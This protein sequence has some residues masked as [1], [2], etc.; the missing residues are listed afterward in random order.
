MWRIKP[1]NPTNMLGTD[2][3]NKGRQWA[4]LVALALTPHLL[5][6]QA[7]IALT[8]VGTY[9]TGSFNA[10]AAEI[11]DFDPIDQRIYFTNAQANTVIALD[12]TDPAALQL[13]FSIDLSPYGAG[14]NSVVVLAGGIAVAVE[15]DPKTDPGSVVF[16]DLDGSFLTQLTVGALPDMITVTPD[17]TKVLVANEGEPNA[18][19][20]IDPVGGVSIIDI[21]GGLNGLSQADVTT[22]DFSAFTVDQ[23]PGVRIFGP[24]ASVAQDM[25]P[26]YIAVSDDSNTAFVVCQENNAVARVDLTTN[27][28]E[29]VTALGAKDHSLPGQGLDPSNTDGAIKI[30]NWP[31][32][33][34]Y[35]PD[36]IDAFSV[37]GQTFVIYANEGDAREYDG[38]VEAARIGAGS[39]VLDPVAFP[40]ASF[41]KQNANLGRLQITKTMG[42][43]DQDGRFEELYVFGARSFSIRDAQ[44]ALVFDSGDQFERI[45][46]AQYPADFNA[47][48]SENGSFDNR[49]D[50]KGP[51]P[52]AVKVALVG[53]RPYAFIGL[54]RIGGIMVYDVSD[55]HA[56]VFVEYVNNR[57]FSGNA[58]AGTAGDLGVEG[59]A[60]VAAENSPLGVPL[61]ITSN[62]ISGTVSVFRVDEAPVEFTLQL[63]H[64]SDFEA[65]T[66]AVQDAPRFAAIVDTLEG[67]YANT[68]KVSSGD[69]ILPSPFMFSGEDPALVA[70][71]KQAYEQYYGGPF[72]NNDLR[73][74][75][76]R[77]DISIM[78]ILGIEAAVLGNHEFD[79][80]TSELR[81]IIGGVASGAA[82]RWFGAQF[83]YLSCNLDM[84][85]DANLAS[86]YT[87]AVEAPAFFRSNPTQTA[88]AIAATKKIAPSTVV[89]VNGERIGLVGVT[90]PLLASISSIG[91]VTVDGPGNGTDDMALLA[92]IVQPAIDALR[93]E[94]GID[95]IILLSHLQQISNEKALAQ[96]LQGVD[97]IVAG[98][99]NTLMADVTDR[100]RAGD[101]A[102]EGYPFLTTG[103]DGDPVAVVNTDG[104]YRYVGRLVVRF[105]AAGRIRPELIDAQVSGAY[106]TDS[107]AVVEAWGDHD[108]AFVAGTKGRAVLDL[109]QAVGGVI[110]AKDGDIYGRTDVYLEGRRDRVRTEET[111][112][113]DLSADANLWIARFHDASV[114]VSIK[115]GGGIRSAIG[116]VTSVGGDVTYGPPA[117][118][119]LAGK[120]EGEVSRL[121]IENSLR[122]NNQLSLITLT[123]EGLRSILEHGVAAS[124][125]GQTPGRFPQVGGLRFRYDGSLAAGARVREAHIVD[126][127]GNITDTFVEAGEVVGD[128]QRTFRVVT[129]NFLAGGGD[130]YPF[131]TLGSDLVD[132]NTLPEA[133]PAQAAFAGA[134]SEQ[135]AFAEYLLAYHSVVPYAQAETV[136]DEDVR[137]REGVDPVTCTEELTL[138]ITL[139]AFGIETTWELLDSEDAVVAAGGPYADGAAGTIVTE[140]I[141]VPQGCY[142]L[143][144]RDAGGNGIT[145]GRYV[146]TDFLDRRVV[147]ATGAFGAVSEVIGGGG[148]LPL[149]FCLP[150]S[151]ARMLP[152]VCDKPSRLITAPVYAST[153]AGATAYEYWIFDPHGTY[154]RKLTLAATQFKPSDLR[155]L[156]VP[157]NVDLNVAVRPLVNGSFLA[158]GQVCRYRFVP[159]QTSA[160]TVNN[161]P[162]FTLFPN[163]VNGNTVGLAFQD[164]PQ[165]T[166]VVDVH[167]FDALGRTVHAGTLAVGVED[168]IQVLDLDA[169]VGQGLYVV[170]IT[171]GEHR[172]TQRLIV[173]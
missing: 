139:D 120:E 96:L 76:G 138:A 86:L 136:A 125:P 163:P 67:T 169:R 35:M 118:N 84:S 70:P 117:A 24:N 25:E 5:P 87:D 161:T 64:A 90:T 58:E 172:L 142:H 150:L 23:L 106:A 13:E 11:A 12:A 60:F 119:P 29:Q 1:L 55:P 65:S 162:G 50:D 68:L 72:A 128:A 140:Q 19:Y 59:I 46:A 40:N 36:A 47:T 109:C 48:N 112:L 32:K 123:A 63:L 22:L 4:T 149:D 97:I 105:D 164:L 170:A 66:S 124:G 133:G 38:F 18:D 57:D 131:N 80:G 146:L 52:E 104:E 93:N 54:E 28:I 31:V 151:G 45:T 79:L 127:A 99:S 61:V 14:V 41:L 53:G 81:N 108:A 129:L 147:D 16:F 137:I 26:E 145:G 167:V 144:V 9:A 155:T 107:L 116:T 122:F 152:G 51:E 102:A 103:A 100:L 10:G 34:L 91:G 111:N 94:H 88:A 71:L 7:Q 3:F 134:G 166:D 85:G 56:P 98:G 49:S 62:E 114:S 21:S 44:G 83:P 158:Y 6:V 159:A 157:V 89:E 132:L 126:D 77:V 73:A 92:T 75:I 165:G 171:V 154:S 82:I 42:D 156:P 153:Y 37:D 95:K 78:N 33:G 115:N 8:H 130:G 39:V 110:V 27:T 17:G 113:G 173:E 2:T 74:G 148:T 30:A 101:T 15:A 143:V 20:S 121:D 168:R 141:C 43:A 160:G 135:D 69:N